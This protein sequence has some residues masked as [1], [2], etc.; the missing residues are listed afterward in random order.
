MGSI[1]ISSTPRTQCSQ[2]YWRFTGLSRIL[3]IGL[4]AHYV[5]F[6]IGHWTAIPV[7]R[8][9]WRFLAEAFE[10]LDDLGILA[11]EDVLVAQ[12]RGHRRV[13]DPCHQRPE[14]R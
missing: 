2:G 12:R 14:A 6:S 8:G 4:R 1:P 7:T 10:L 3:R 5:P 13:T 9:R 11:V